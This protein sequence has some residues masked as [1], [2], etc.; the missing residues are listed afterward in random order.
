MKYYY[1]SVS[2]DFKEVGIYP[3]STSFNEIGSVQEYGLGFNAPIN[4]IKL[5]ELILDNK[6]KLTNLISVTYINRSVFLILDHSFI[7]MLKSNDSINDFQ[8]WNLKVLKKN[9]TINNY[10]LF[11][12][13][14]PSDIDIIDFEKSTFELSNDNLGSGIKKRFEDYIDYKKEWDK[15]INLGNTLKFEKIFLD[16][17]KMNSDLIRILNID[18][19]FIGYYIS[20]PLKKAIEKERFTG[21]VFQ[22]IEEIDKRIKA[23]Y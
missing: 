3:Q 12:L 16:F 4:S 14:Y 19:M 6:A 22:E 8:Y 9:S 10:Y 18:S 5:P 20:E 7:S 21:L 23:I 2:I 15:T 1:L 17:R 13:S 11:H